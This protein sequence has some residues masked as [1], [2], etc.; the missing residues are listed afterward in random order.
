MTNQRHLIDCLAAIVNSITVLTQKLD[1]DGTVTDTNYTA[2]W[3]TATI[4]MVVEDCYGNQYG[5]NSSAYT[6]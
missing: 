6:H 2:L 4:L 5:N 1:A 3:Y